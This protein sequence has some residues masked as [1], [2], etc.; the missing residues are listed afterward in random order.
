MNFRI[1]LAIKEYGN[2]NYM[3]VPCS[4]NVICPLSDFVFL[5]LLTFSWFTTPRGWP[6]W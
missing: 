4:E 6:K 2:Q 1:S 3:D 5:S